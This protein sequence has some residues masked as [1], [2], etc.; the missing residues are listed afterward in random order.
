MQLPSY[1][2]VSCI[3]KV[4]SATCDLMPHISANT[5]NTGKN[6][7]IQLAMFSIIIAA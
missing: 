3:D 4:M 6:L 2:L 7:K 1:Q 5:L